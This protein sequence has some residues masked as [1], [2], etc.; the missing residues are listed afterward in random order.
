MNVIIV[1]SGK[2]G[3]TLAEH[4]SQEDHDVTIIDT[5]GETLH[6]ASETLDV[7][8]IKGTGA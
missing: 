7:M 3:Y 6:R 2:V 8:C 5:D 1:G 4:L